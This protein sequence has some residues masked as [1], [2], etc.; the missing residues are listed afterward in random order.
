VEVDV[1]A[2]N[3]AGPARLMV[4]RLLAG[5]SGDGGL[6]GLWSLAKAAQLATLRLA[7]DPATDPDLAMT[8]A[9][10]DIGEVLEELEWAHPDVRLLAVA[11][12]L[13][14]PP[15]DPD[16]GRE[17]IAALLVGPLDVVAAVLRAP[18]GSPPRRRC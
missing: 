11:V 10:M 14:E 17:V 12:D 13:G 8:H 2:E 16:T 15:A 5:A 1:V 9:G 6:S 18:M 3:W 7:L 4:Q